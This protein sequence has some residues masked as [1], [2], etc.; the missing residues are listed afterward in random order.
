MDS[1]HEKRTKKRQDV[2][3]TS[4]KRGRSSKALAGHFPRPSHHPS[5]SSDDE[6]DEHELY[7][8]YAPEER[9]DHY[10]IRYSKKSKQSTISENWEAPV[11][12]GSKQ[13][14]DPRFWSLFH[15]DWYHSIYLNKAK[16]V[17]ETQ[18]VNWD[19]MAN[20]RHTIFNQIKVTCDELVMT[21]MMSF[22]YDW[23]KEII[24]QFYATLYFDADAQKLV[25]MS[26]G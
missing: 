3:R 18:W 26:T 7:E 9:H 5:H 17:V 6:Q 21:K 2:A 19:W 24:C 25:W 12:E 22:K 16:P 23:N 15:S 4:S 8:R 10:A 20:K 14:H 1:R 13:S 11:Y